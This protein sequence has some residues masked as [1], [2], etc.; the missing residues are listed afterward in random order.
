MESEV[1]SHRGKTARQ[2]RSYCCRKK[3]DHVYQFK[4]SLQDIDATIWRQIQVPDRYSFW[5]LHCAITDAFGWLDYHLHQFKILFPESGEEDIIGIPDDE[6]F[7]GAETLPGWHLYLAEY[8]SMENKTCNYDY[9]FG[10]GWQHSVVLEAILPREQGASYP[11]CIAGE[12]ACPPE[13]VGGPWGYER[14]LKSINY[15]NAPDRDRLLEWCGGWFDAE[16]F[17]LSLIRFGN[18][19]KRWDIAFIN[20]PVAETLR[21]VQYH[22]MR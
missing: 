2:P 18:P 14:F 8:F 13:D 21:T 20:E 9:D 7:D 6:G 10:D 17:D 12:R 3:F 4:V 16:W 15:M 22:M 1:A 19:Q 11:R 5:D